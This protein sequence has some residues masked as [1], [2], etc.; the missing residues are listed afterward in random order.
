ML[1]ND[2][3]YGDRNIG[4]ESL[5]QYNKVSIMELFTKELYGKV[6]LMVDT[7]PV[8]EYKIQAEVWVFTRDDLLAML[9]TS[10]ET[11]ARLVSS[12]LKDKER[13]NKLL[14][15]KELIKFEEL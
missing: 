15:T 10:S 9:T 12:L 6:S 8:D 1:V 4:K 2:L 13:E 7:T 14:K 5:K 3:L 11:K